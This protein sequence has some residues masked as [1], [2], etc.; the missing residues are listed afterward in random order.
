MAKNRNLIGSIS[1][2]LG[3]VVDVEFEEISF[4]FEYF[5]SR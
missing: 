2:V 3:A 5:R 4:N 1:Q